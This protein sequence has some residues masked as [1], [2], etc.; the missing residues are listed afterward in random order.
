MKLTRIIVI[1]EDTINVGATG[2]V[3]AVCGACDSYELDIIIYDTICSVES[4]K[5]IKNLTESIAQASSDTV[6]A[7]YIAIVAH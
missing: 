1:E 6:K 2:V 3:P 5:W 7:S 4:S